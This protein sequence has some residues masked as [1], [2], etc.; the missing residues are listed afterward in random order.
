MPAFVVS[1]FLSA[2][3]FFWIQ[4]LL[5]RFILPWFGG[6]PAV[7]SCCL[8]FF[9]AVL[10]A[11]Y[12]WSHYLLKLRSISVQVGLQLAMCATAVWFLPLIPAGAGQRADEASVW[13]ILF[14]LGGVAGLPCLAL[15]TT[16]SLLQAWFARCWP[17][18]SPY[19][20]YALSNA[21]SL[22]ALALAT[23]WFDVQFTRETQARIWAGS[24]VLYGLAILSAGV[25]AI[26]SKPAAAVLEQSRE[27]QESH[28]RWLWLALPFCSSTLLLSITAKLTQDYAVVPFLWTLPL[29]L[30]LFTYVLAFDHPRWY[31]RRF[32]AGALVVALIFIW[33]IVFFGRLQGNSGFFL[34]LLA[35]LAVLGFGCQFCHGELYRLR[36]KIHDLSGYYL[37]IAGGG[38]LGG[39][40]VSLAAPAWF[41]THAELPLSLLLCAVLGAVVYLRE[42]RLNARLPDTVRATGYLVG[43]VLVYALAWL[44]YTASQRLGKIASD[45]NFFGV[46]SILERAKGT[47]DK[48]RYVMMNGPTLHG[49]Q[50]R[51]EERQ[52]EPTSYYGRS[53]GLGLA[54]S[55]FGEKRNLKIGAI[56][57]GTGTLATYGRFGDAITFYEINPLVEAFARSHFTFLSSTKATIKIILGDARI[58]LSA[59]DANDFDV[60]IIDAFNTGTIPIHLLTKEAFALWKSH[61]RPDAVIVIHITNHHLDLQPVIAAGA[62]S[63]NYQARFYAERVS[64]KKTMDSGRNSSDWCVLAPDESFFQ[65]IAFAQRG[66]ELHQTQPPLIWTDE[67]ASLIPLLK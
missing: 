35:H 11:G 41:R 66:S 50:Y 65:H 1:I 9:Q 56:G 16:A 6:V 39:L 30:Y 33:V 18:H 22:L 25:I 37:G 32:C 57:L 51:S 21:A 52:E 19:R 23:F 15:A 53:G 42:H 59:E 20:L 47:P 29:G 31:P 27:K 5:G 67:K 3:L 48:R 63:I 45:R 49:L 34:P 38:L 40:F 60:L 61:L 36:P 13:T 43:G 8:L 24:F 28:S 58:R 7:W 46:C 14:L 10:F 4:P 54:W 64:Q 44:A 17:E 62:Q 2:F 55:V 26:R 12:A